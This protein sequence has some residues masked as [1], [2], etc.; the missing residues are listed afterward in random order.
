MHELTHTHNNLARVQ[1]HTITT[2]TQQNS[3]YTIVYVNK[4]VK[5]IDVSESSAQPLYNAER[6]DRPKK[7]HLR[8]AVFNPIDVQT[9]S[10]H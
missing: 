7:C 10:Q 8:L 2:H 3:L 9:Q 5:V 4:S 1:A 6:N